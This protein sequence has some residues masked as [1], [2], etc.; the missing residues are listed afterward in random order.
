MAASIY[1]IQ[2]ILATGYK[3]EN[4]ELVGGFLNETPFLIPCAY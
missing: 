1:N 2:K 4:Q 3:V